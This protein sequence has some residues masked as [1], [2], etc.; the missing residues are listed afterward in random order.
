M[1]NLF[2]FFYHQTHHRWYRLSDLDLG[3]AELCLSE[4]SMAAIAK[5]GRLFEIFF[6]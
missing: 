6:T 1:F 5:M 2:F 4:S 3:I